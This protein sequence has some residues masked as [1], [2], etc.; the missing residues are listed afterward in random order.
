MPRPLLALVCIL[1]VFAPE[2]DFREED[3][4]ADAFQDLLRDPISLPVAGL[5]P[6]RSTD[7][8]P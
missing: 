2:A 5:V 8:I 7:L 3:L 4:K 1:A 6:G